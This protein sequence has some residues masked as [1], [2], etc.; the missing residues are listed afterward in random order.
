VA[1]TDATL[2]LTRHERGTARSFG[3]LAALAG[4][5]IIAM[6]SFRI[7]SISISTQ[8]A[9]DALFNYDAANYNQTVVRSL[10]LPRTVIALGV[11]AGLAVAGAVM[12]A[13]TRNPLAGPSILGV[14][15][16]GAFAIVTAMG[17]TQLPGGGSA[18]GPGT[19]AARHA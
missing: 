6:L 13:V 19:G 16:G 15:S 14:S 7:G 9:W 2:E 3:L 10:R 11:G 4:V 12:Q 1:T 5:V 8:D 18:A 17:L